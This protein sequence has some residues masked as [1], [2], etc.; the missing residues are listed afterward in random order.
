LS[1]RSPAKAADASVREPSAASTT[2]STLSYES[3]YLV[4]RTY[5]SYSATL[6]RLYSV[7]IV[8]DVAKDAV[9]AAGH[10]VQQGEGLLLLES[11]KFS[12]NSGRSV[13]T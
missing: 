1:E 12:E 13:E 6:R 3:L 4:H 7:V 2:S 10:R 9:V 5:S 11:L 8:W